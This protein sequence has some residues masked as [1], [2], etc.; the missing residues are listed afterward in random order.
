MKLAIVNPIY[1]NLGW[2][3]QVYP[4]TNGCIHAS[5]HIESSR[6]FPTKDDAIREGKK[7]AKNMGWRI[8][9]K[10][11]VPKNEMTNPKPTGRGGPNRGQGRKPRAIPREKI[12]V[13]LDPEDANK[14]RTICKEQEVSQATWVTGKIRKEKPGRKKP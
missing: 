3:F 8:A 1:Q 12:T 13:A 14:L 10:Q 4:P 6:S 11:H 2:S 5:K 9:M 7:L